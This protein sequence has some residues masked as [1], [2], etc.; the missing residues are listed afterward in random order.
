MS[1][2][3]ERDEFIL[4][5]VDC[6]AERLTARP[7]LD[8]RVQAL[9][10]QVVP[11]PDNTRHVCTHATSTVIKIMLNSAKEGGNTATF[12]DSRPYVFP[13]RKKFLD[14]PLHRQIQHYST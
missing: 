4:N 10:R 13:K 9:L 5:T 2:G 11:K 1:V 3:A 14:P 8:N 12:G 6:D 7:V